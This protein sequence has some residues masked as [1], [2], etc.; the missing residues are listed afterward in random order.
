MTFRAPGARCVLSSLALTILLL[1]AGRA[2]AHEAGRAGVSS[3]GVVAGAALTVERPGPIQ[4]FAV[5]VPRQSGAPSQEPSRVRSWWGWLLLGRLHPMVVHFPIALLTVAAVIEAWHVLR[6]RPVPSEAG[7]YCLAFG[8]AGA[9]ASVCLGTLNAAHQSMTGEAAAAL[10]RHQVM[11]W[12]STVAAMGALGAGQFVRRAGQMRTVAVYVGLLVVTGAVVGATGHLGGELVYGERYLTGVLP[13]NQAAPELASASP[14]PAVTPHV[15]S[16]NGQG[17]AVD[18]T[19]DV[20]PILDTT[21][22]ECH[23]PDKV[24]ARLRMDSVA[25]LQ[26]GGKSGALLKPGDPENSLIMRRV[27]GL[28]DEDQMPLDKDPLTEK[29]IDTL[30]RWIAAG[31]VYPGAGSQ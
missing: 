9:V 10:E 29:Q 19:R 12:I 1:T 4:P 8:V 11:G 2:V 3:P 27:L 14:T 28:D 23:G 25:A 18:F 31:A 20:M 5:G 21:C 13:W 22:V 15:S 16:T 6:R 7:T 30:R 17:D 24:K 26:K